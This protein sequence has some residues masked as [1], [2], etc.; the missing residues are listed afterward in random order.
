V[1]AGHCGSNPQPT[2][3]DQSPFGTVWLSRGRF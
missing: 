1:I 2:W 3:I